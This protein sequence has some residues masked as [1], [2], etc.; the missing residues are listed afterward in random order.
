AVLII[1]MVFVAF[2][3]KTGNVFPT[4]NYYVLPFVPVMAFLAAYGLNKAPLKL[5]YVLLAV[6]VFEGVLNQQHDFFIKDSEKYKLK[7]EQI[8]SSSIEKN[9]LIVI[10]GGES[11]QELYFTNRRGWTV[12]HS[13]LLS[14]TFIDSLANRGAAYLILDKKK[15]PA[16]TTNYP[17]VYKDD[18]F[19]VLKLKD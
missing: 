19:E 1:T 10:N 17:T 16:I 15:E 4:H 8:A 2:V 11:P 5:S 6:I 13:K 14:P 18:F 9:A 3:I 12:E 7:L